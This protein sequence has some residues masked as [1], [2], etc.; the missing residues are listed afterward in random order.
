[1]RLEI[2]SDPA[3][4]PRVR[5]SVRRVALAAGFDEEEIASVVL[6]TDEAIANVI[7]H[8]YGGRTDRPVEVSLIHVEEGQREGIAITLRDFGKQVSPQ[9]IRSRA[10]DDVRPGGLGVHII[11]S[12]M[13][14]VDF[15]A[16]DG[17]GMRLEMIKFRK[18]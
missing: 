14:R 6:A 12:V 17:G 5:D 3:E 9:Q 18:P 7:K 4:L 1:M 10:L 16:A 15:A 8:G 13:D 2:R 11:R